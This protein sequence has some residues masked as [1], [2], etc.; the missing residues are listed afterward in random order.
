[1]DAC[2]DTSPIDPTVCPAECN[3][4]N[5]GDF[6]GFPSG[7]NT[8]YP[9][10]IPPYNSEVILLQN[11][12]SNT[13]DVL[14]SNGNQYLRM[15][16]SLSGNNHENGLFPLC[17]S[18][19]AGCNFT[20]DF[21]A[22]AE[23]LNGEAQSVTVGIWALS[24]LPAGLQ[25]PTDIPCNGQ[26]FDNQGTLIGTCIGE[27]ELSDD[28]V[29]GNVVFPSSPFTFSGVHT[30]P[31]SYIWMTETNT[32]GTFSSNVYIDNMN[33]RKDCEDQIS[34]DPIILSACSGGQAIID[35]EVCNLGTQN[36]FS[37]VLIAPYLG[38]TNGVNFAS[39]NPDF[40]NG[41]AN[42]NVL[43][44]GDCT[45]RTLYLDLDP[46]LTPGT[47]ITFPVNIVSNDICVQNETINVSFQIEE[48]TPSVCD[49]PQGSIQIGSP[50][51]ETYLADLVAQQT[52]PSIT[53][54]FTS[55]NLTIS[56]TLIINADAIPGNTG[57]TYNFGLGTNV[58]MEPGAE[59][60]VP[61]NSVLNLWSN[62]IRGCDKRWKSITVKNKG[63]L[64][65]LGYGQGLIEDGQHA[66]TAETGST[67]TIDQV[68]FDKNFIAIYSEQGG[69]TLNP[70]SGNTIECSDALLPHFDSNDPEDGP[71][72]FAG[73][74]V[75]NQILSVGVSNGP[76][77]FFL[78]LRNGI[79]V[80]SGSL[81][82]TNSQFNNIERLDYSQAGTAVTVDQGGFFENVGDCSSPLSVLF[83]NCRI[84]IFLRN[85][86][87]KARTNA[88]TNMETGI[89]VRDCIWKRIV[90]CNND[91]Q[92]TL[93]GVSLFFNDPAAAISV[94]ANDIT[95][96]PPFPDNRAAGIFVRENNNDQ[97]SAQIGDANNITTVGA[98]SG[99]SVMS[100]SDYN[101]HENNIQ[102]SN[103][104]LG[105]LAYAGIRIEQC[106]APFICT[107]NVIGDLNTQPNGD[108][109]GPFGIRMRS[110]LDAIFECNSVN[111]TYIGVQFDMPCDNTRFATTSFDNHHFGLHYTA[112]GRTGLQPPDGIPPLHGNRWNGTWMAPD[113]IGARHESDNPDFVN[114][115]RYVV[116]KLDA[117]FG[118]V[119]P[120]SSSSSW[121]T[122]DSL[123]ELQCDIIC[124]IIPESYP[125]DGWTEK[126]ARGQLT[127]GVSD[128]SINWLQQYNLYKELREDPSQIVP[129]SVLDSF[130]NANSSTTIGRFVLLES[131]MHGLFGLDSMTLARLDGFSLAMQSKMAQVVNFDTL[132]ASASGQDS[133]DMLNQRAQLLIE[134]D[135]LSDLYT[136]LTDSLDWQRS[137]AA[138]A[139]IAQ[140]YSISTS[141]IWEDNLKTVNHIFLNTLA[142][143]SAP[144]GSQ[145]DLLRSIA[146]QCPWDGGM[147][148]FKARSLMEGWT[149]EHFEDALPCGGGQQG[150]VLPPIESQVMQFF[151]IY[152][153]PA[154]NQVEVVLSQPAGEDWKL[155]LLGLQGQLL[156]TY[157]IPLESTRI[158]LSLPEQSNGIYWL[159]LKKTGG[160][161]QAQKLVIQN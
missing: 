161:I 49:C 109:N 146:Q 1:M 46:S 139:L 148:V 54:P 86:D 107:N 114:A 131:D 84:G 26:L 32:H 138:D 10:F 119:N 79:I 2:L 128:T 123:E 78:D 110:S 19:P 61:T 99:I 11:S 34:V 112:T 16:N 108:M 70:F 120:E 95:I 66:I 129:G 92:A 90:I 72:S 9:N 116:P 74:K 8:Y 83:D 145:F 45:T 67:L 77:N 23:I 111:S 52:L 58:C 140:N 21:Q 48:C 27:V 102:I 160:M 82:L 69:F 81:T 60:V 22:C 57:S 96:S 38:G 158:I 56:G 85:V 125:F 15:I 63:K 150:L 64:N 134:V 3:L 47:V 101:I 68:H 91:I 24:Q 141:D 117:P 132:L 118:P 39:N 51:A 105:I 36:L 12:P 135:S 144:T 151:R 13:P 155:E 37:S 20:V 29:F 133:L 93:R 31:V 104:P 43:P 14:S 103:S 18:I 4:L 53:S 73:I 89:L 87:I 121:F 152:P 142:K 154:K 106:E 71:W 41:I 130:Y 35:F 124:E 80:N 44:A 7:Q 76:A 122:V 137:L 62:H 115:S 75:K 55:F 65:V 157:S 42:V 100:S 6:E 127:P 25:L 5:Y 159:V 113:A 143:Q 50:G 33:V 28:C 97:V 88:M 59:I 149:E 94:Y 40:P 30:S 98:G 126:I 17:Q 147:A 153:N 156:L 136:A